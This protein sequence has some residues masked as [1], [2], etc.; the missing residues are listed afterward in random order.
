MA[1]YSWF[2][3][4]GHH[5][6]PVGYSY[7]LEVA[8]LFAES[9]RQP[10]QDAAD[11]GPA[12]PIRCGYLTTARVLLERLHALGITPD[13]ARTDLAAGLGSLTDQPRADGLPSPIPA[14]DGFLD[15][16]RALLATNSAD[17]ELDSGDLEL[18]QRW[19]SLNA[20]IEA[21]RGHMDTRSLLSLLLE[22]SPRHA[23]AGLDL[24]E[25]DCDCTALGPH[26]PV[27]SRA[28]LDQLAEVAQNAP[29]LV[30]TEGSTDASLLKLGMRVTHPHLVGFVNFMDFNLAPA[31]RNV[32]AL[33]KTVNAF[34]VAGVANRF[35][36]IADNDT[37]A[38]DGLDKL[39][40]REHPQ[41]CRVLH[42][43]PLDFLAAYPA[44]DSDTGRLTSTNVNGAAG[45]LELYFG[46]DVLTGDDGTLMPVQWGGLV[47]KLGR[48]QGAL[49]DADKKAAQKRFRQKAE[50]A[51]TGNSNGDEDWDGIRAIID[52]ILHAFG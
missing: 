28:R 3:V 37:A 31:E 34:I 42:Y 32:S 21:L 10:C 52:T 29:L 25:L 24:T 27:A 49:S 33:G 41:S 5:F 50:A 17:L 51:L 2:K 46:R 19:E 30:L 1:D 16:L 11:D 15:E 14:R 44:R 48:R 8:A 6:L 23:L 47:A 26:Q 36:A 43:P 9:E 7:E 4:G 40:A 12:P 22:T 20:L 45:S 38:H 35:V 13:R 39:K 18:F